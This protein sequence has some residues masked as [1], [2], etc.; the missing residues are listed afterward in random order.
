MILLLMVIWV[1]R[2]FD[3]CAKFSDVNIIYLVFSI[4]SVSLF[5]LNQS[6][7]ISSSLFAVCTV[8]FNLF[9]V[10]IRLV[11]SAKEI[12][13]LFFKDLKRFFL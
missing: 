10:I 7:R 6:L 8:S 3:C 4:F 11:S 12:S 5:S 13:L 2:F 9:P 1:L